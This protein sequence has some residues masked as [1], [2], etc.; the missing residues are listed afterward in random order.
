MVQPRVLS[1]AVVVV[2]TKEKRKQLQRVENWVYRQIQGAP[3][4]TPLTDYGER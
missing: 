3:V 1:V 2:W 4:Y